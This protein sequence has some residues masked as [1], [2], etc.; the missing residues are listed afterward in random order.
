M[1]NQL[2]SQ[3][4]Q[5]L[6]SA[7]KLVETRRLIRPQSRGIVIECNRDIDAQIVIDRAVFRHL[8]GRRFG[9][10]GLL[11]AKA[12][13]LTFQRLRLQTARDLRLGQFPGRRRLGKTGRR[14]DA[15]SQTQ[16]HTARYLQP[17]EI[18]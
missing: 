1:A 6:Q 11:H 10:F 3:L 12:A 9:G 17:H 15:Q 13:R 16:K 4:W 18:T 8:I 14:G 7:A 5:I 2:K